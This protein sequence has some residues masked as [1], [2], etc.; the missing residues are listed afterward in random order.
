MKSHYTVNTSFSVA[1]LIP[2]IAGFM[3]GVPTHTVFAEVP[4]A[5]EF[6]LPGT[7]VESEVPTPPEA[8]PTAPTTDTNTSTETPTETTQQSSSSHRS[9]GGGGGSS[10][11]SSSS[12]TKVASASTYSATA[13]AALAKCSGPT[14]PASE[15]DGSP[16][17]AGLID[18]FVALGIIPQDRAAKA[19]A[20]LVSADTTT[21]TAVSAQAFTKTLSL[22]ETHADVI[23]LQQFLNA[24]GFTIAT[25]GTGAKGQESAYYGVKTA[26][27]VARF[28]EAYRTEI[29]TPRS[30]QNGTGNF[31]QATMTK[32]N[33]LLGK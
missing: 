18:L 14:R 8:A 23:R 31:D 20:A 27:A 33:Q 10:R 17:L 13:V 5:P 2:A 11:R 26:V 32:A 21:T 30:L 3:L 28:Q 19:C 15:I 16:T 7:P 9:G 1:L 25:T 24:R 12:S 22:G 4:P 29:L 6:T